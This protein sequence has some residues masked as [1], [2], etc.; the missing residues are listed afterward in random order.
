MKVSWG[1][2]RGIQ[3]VPVRVRRGLG[4]LREFWGG[5]SIQRAPEGGTKQGMRGSEGPPG[6]RRGVQR[7]PGELEGVE[8]VRGSHQRGLVVVG[9]LWVLTALAR[10]PR[11]VPAMAAAIP[12]RPLLRMFMATLKPP[13]GTPRTFSA[14]TRTPS[15]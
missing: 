10:T 7:G 14:G 9:G 2:V 12:K 8:G 11:M 1:S 5:Q 4:G 15:K 6:A 3:R 13:P